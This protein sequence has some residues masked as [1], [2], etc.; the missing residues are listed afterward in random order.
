MLSRLR[1]RLPTLFAYG[2]DPN[3][4]SPLH[5]QEHAS[6]RPNALLA[7]NLGKNKSSPAESIDDF[8]A[9]VHTFG[10]YADALVVNVSSPNTPGLRYAVF[11]FL[12]P[13]PPECHPQLNVCAGR[14]MQS[15]TVLQELLGGVIAARDEVTT[16]ST[17]SHRP[18]LLL[19][20]APDLSEQEVADVAAAVLAAGDIDGVIVSNTTVQRPASLSDR[21]YRASP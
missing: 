2:S 4:Q 7:V 1:A 5:G 6:L 9:G 20:I 21:A 8:V 16:L 17:H 18:K 19:K 11:S 10:P 15:R 12:V 14:G 13:K 3:T